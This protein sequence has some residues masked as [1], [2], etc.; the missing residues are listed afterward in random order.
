MWRRY[1]DQST[2]DAANGHSSPCYSFL[3]LE[4]VL[5]S[6]HTLACRILLLALLF[7]MSQTKALQIALAESVSFGPEPLINLLRQHIKVVRPLLILSPFY[8]ERAICF[9]SYLFDIRCAD[10]EKAVRIEYGREC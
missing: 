9:P 6:L 5:L 3:C 2:A 7:A 10:L 8:M 1:I 4:S